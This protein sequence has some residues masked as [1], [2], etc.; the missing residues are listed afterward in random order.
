M[1]DMNTLL[2]L[3]LKEK[4]KKEMKP[5]KTYGRRLKAFRELMN[6]RVKTLNRIPTED[7]FDVLFKNQYLDL[8][9]YNYNGMSL[10]MDSMEWKAKFLTLYFAYTTDNIDR[11][12]TNIVRDLDVDEDIFWDAKDAVLCKIYEDLA[13]LNECMIAKHGMYNNILIQSLYYTIYISEKGNHKEY[14]ESLQ[15]AFANIKRVANSRDVDYDILAHDIFLIAFA[16]AT[17]STKFKN[18]PSFT[19]F[20]GMTLDDDFSRLV[21]KLGKAIYKEYDKRVLP[22]MFKAFIDSKPLIASNIDRVYRSN[23]NLGIV[24]LYYAAFIIGDRAVTDV[25]ISL[26][27]K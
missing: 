8:S 7:N 27:T 9:V 11:V 22:M 2:E 18:V 17:G 25:V 3:R 24:A 13:K 6:T 26:V 12:V 19:D 15:D 23:V 10:P 20:D 1:V 4:K 21:E 16:L 14:T 5:K